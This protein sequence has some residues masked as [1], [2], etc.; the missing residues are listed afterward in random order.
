MKIKTI[1]KG[2]YTEGEMNVSLMKIME[3]IYVF[4]KKPENYE[5]YFSI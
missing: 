5:S 1:N 2:K 4:N 3:V